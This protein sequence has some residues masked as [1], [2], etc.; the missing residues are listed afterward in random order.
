MVGKKTCRDGDFVEENVGRG[1][2][3]RAEVGQS[4]IYHRYVF[5]DIAGVL[6]VC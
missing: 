4:H 1:T 2:A 6:L 3:R 5:D